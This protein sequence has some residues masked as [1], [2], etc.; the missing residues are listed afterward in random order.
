MLEMH[1]CS[2][3]HTS[4]ILHNVHLEKSSLW[5]MLASYTEIHVRVKHLSKAP[6]LELWE[7]LVFGLLKRHHPCYV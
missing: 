5:A 3:P 1:I 7:S 6:K 4:S 2:C